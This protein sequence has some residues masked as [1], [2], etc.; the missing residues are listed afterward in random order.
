M[1]LARIPSYILFHTVAELV[2]VVVCLSVIIMAWALYQFLDDDFAVFL[3]AALFAV[4]SLHVVHVVD[5]PGLGLVG[6]SLD[7]PTQLWLAARFLL[8]AA[9]IAAAFVVGRRIDLRI[10]ALVLAGYVAVVLAS[11]YWWDAFPETLHDG[12]LTTFKTAAEYVIC[13]LLVVATVLLWQRRERLPGGTWRLLRAAL[14]ASIVAEVW[15]T[16]YQVASQWPNMLGHFFLALSAVLL[17]RAVV[18]DGLARPHALAVNALSEAETMHRRLE[19]ALM[20]SLPV[21]RPGLTVLS[22]YLPGEERLQLGGDFIDVLDRGDDGVAVICGDVSGHG[23]NPAA[24]GAMLRVSWQSLCAA[25]VDATTMVDSLREVIERERQSEWTYATICLAWIDPQLGELRL[26]SLG[27][28][29]PLLVADGSVAPVQVRPITPLGLWDDPVVTPS[30]IPLPDGWRLFFYT[31]G[32]I[33]GRVAPGSSERFG[34][35][36]LVEA[37]ERLCCASFDEQCL[38]ELLEEV[39]NA[40]CEP[41]ADDVSVILVSQASEVRPREADGAVPAPQATRQAPGCC[42]ATPE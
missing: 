39:R 33:E 22:S 27:H 2:F 25:D 16:L 12:G 8:A 23:A 7:S 32:L 20:P 41:F 34:E 18:D 37:V 26:V 28:P 5:Y 40:G 36:R 9:L 17:F 19:Q 13:A 3:G 15:F 29:L 4:A 10:T 30:I 38:E 31:D 6:G 21:D 1:S 42:P 24:L 11:I 35:G 14:V